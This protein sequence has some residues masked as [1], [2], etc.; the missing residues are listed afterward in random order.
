MKT[1]AVAGLK[2]LVLGNADLN[3]LRS[4]KDDTGSDVVFWL[5]VAPFSSEFMASFNADAIVPF[6]ETADGT[7]VGILSRDGD[8][9]ENL[10]IETGVNAGDDISNFFPDGEKFTSFT[11]FD[12][13]I[14]D[15]DDFSFD[16]AGLKSGTLADESGV[17]FVLSPAAKDGGDL[18]ASDEKF[19]AGLPNW[20]SLLSAEDASG[21]ILDGS[22]F[23]GKS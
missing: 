11:L 2:E 7:N 1:G 6:S 22:I 9:A 10:F 19:I 14:I 3:E 21:F 16:N 15:P 17:V 12:F 13:N 4:F 20:G 23:S 18:V 8:N 5:V